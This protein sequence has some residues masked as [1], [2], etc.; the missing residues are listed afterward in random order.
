MNTHRLPLLLAAIAWLLPASAWP[1]QSARLPTVGILSPGAPTACTSGAPGFVAACMVDG[2]RALGDVGGRKIAFET[3][4]AHGDVSR[5]PALAAELV[6]L[7]L[8]VLYTFTGAGADAA[9]K[10][11]A[12]IPIV[13]GPASEAVMTRLAGNLARPTGNVTGQTIDTGNNEQSQ[14][15][16]QL[17]KELAPRASR[18][19]WIGNPDNPGF[20]RGRTEM[21]A[22][23]TQL[24]LTLV[25]V[26]ARGAADLP[27]V[28]AA[29]SAMAAGRADA[30]FM[31]D[32]AALAGSG[33]VRRLVSA[34]ALS[35]R[36]PLASSNAWF[37]ADGALLSLGTDIPAIAR[38]AAFYVHR[39][40]GGAKPADLP[41]E[42]PT[43]FKLS[44][45]AKTAAALG[46]TIPQVLLLRADEVIQ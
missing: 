27:Q 35:R 45:N 40:L 18:V 21:D 15:S 38:R 9:A 4:Y 7:R 41:V 3:R 12:T 22:A 5:L 39:I 6:A 19:V 42:R 24:G 31:G 29:T 20:I 14:K 34:W 23:A 28:F 44:L 8:D 37:A 46:I 11:T 33:E 1:Q 43:V 17:L 30:I 25:R 16:L 2:L 10:A 26:E 36:L 13:V 32:D